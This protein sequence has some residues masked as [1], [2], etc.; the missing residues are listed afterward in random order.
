M[1]LRSDLSLAFFTA[2]TFYRAGIFKTVSQ[3][4]GSRWEA[5]DKHVLYWI[6]HMTLNVNLKSRRPL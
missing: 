6:N 1:V 2:D 5:T 3:Q 4:V